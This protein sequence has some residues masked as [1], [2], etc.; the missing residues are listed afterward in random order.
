MVESFGR[1]ARSRLRHAI[2]DPWMTSKGI[3]LA[4]SPFLSG[5]GARAACDFTCGYYFGATGALEDMNHAGVIMLVSLSCWCHYHAGVSITLASL[6]RGCHDHPG[7][8]VM[9]RHTAATVPHAVSLWWWCGFGAMPLVWDSWT[10]RHASCAMTAAYSG[11]SRHWY[12]PHAAPW[13][14]GSRR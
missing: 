10:S 5:R 4:L 11:R 13:C 1:D 6:T 3:E 7:V 9:L 14:P 12:M 2:D 8:I